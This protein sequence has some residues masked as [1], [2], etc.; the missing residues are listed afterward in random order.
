M[1]ADNKQKEKKTTMNQ[2]NLEDTRSALIVKLIDSYS[3][4]LLDP[5]FSTLELHKLLYLMQETGEEL[6]LNFVNTAIF[7]GVY[8]ED[9]ID[10]VKKLDGNLISVTINNENNF[11]AHLTLFPNALNWSDSVLKGNNKT[12]SNLSKV[13]WLVS[14]W[15]SPFGMELLTSVQWIVTKNY[16]QK[17]MEDLIKIIKKSSENKFSNR[18]IKLAFNWLNESGWL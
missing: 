11:D 8:S 18:Q 15:E 7:N 4:G 14:G 3:R 13:C 10:I 12:Q 6:S 2:K 17:S 16:S 1:H 9:L 5:F